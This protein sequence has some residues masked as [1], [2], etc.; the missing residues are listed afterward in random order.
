MI[1]PTQLDD[2][3]NKEIILAFM[4]LSE[5]NTEWVQE[6]LEVEIE[7][8]IEEYVRAIPE[9]KELQLIT[10]LHMCNELWETACD[11]LYE[12]DFEN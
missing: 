3:S 1:H 10:D 4:E 5:H 12:V 6:H 2:M 8:T 7:S 11:N 9:S